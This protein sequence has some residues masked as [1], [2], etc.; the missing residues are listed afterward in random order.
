M[1]AQFPVSVEY[2]VAVT[3]IVLPV[4]ALVLVLVLCVLVLVLVLGF[5]LFG[6]VEL[7]TLLFLCIC[8][9]SHFFLHLF[10]C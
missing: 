5:F 1:G 2:P 7:A 9:F 3:T 4:K 6:C 10:C 8:F